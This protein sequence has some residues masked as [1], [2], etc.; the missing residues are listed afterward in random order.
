M[1]FGLFCLMTQRDASQSIAKLYDDNLQL[2]KLAEDVGFD[3]AWLA[4]HHFSNYSMC[5]SPHIMAG[6]L[7]PQ[8]KRI[9]L[10]AAILVL[11]LYQP[12]RMLEEIGM[13]DILSQG[14]TVIGIGAGY[15]DFEFKR[16]GV[17]LEHN[18]EMTHEMLD[19]IAPADCESLGRTDYDDGFFAGKYEN[20]VSCGGTDTEYVVVATISA[21]GTYG[22]V[23]AVQ[24]VTAAD[25]EALDQIMRTFNVTTGAA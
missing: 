6:Y 8:T 1:N 23:V 12:V 22:V 11:P 14:R 4:E 16:F 25:Y 3:I 19:L 18:W 21:D 7:A 24:V 9:K 17:K 13:V 5:P 2:V 10:G 20:F 15:Q